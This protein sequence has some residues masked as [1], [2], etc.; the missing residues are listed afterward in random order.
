[1]KPTLKSLKLF[2]EQKESAAQEEQERRHLCLKYGI[3]PECGATLIEEK[4]EKLDKPEKYLF[5]LIVLR[6]R[7][8]DNRI[9][10]SADK[11]HYEDK[12]D[13]YSFTD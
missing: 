4:K 9:I 8:W 13:E 11:R 6:Y 10:C 3:C 5:G 7:K 2:H 12:F 1:M